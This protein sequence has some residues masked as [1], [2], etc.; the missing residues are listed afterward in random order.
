MHLAWDHMCHHYSKSGHEPEAGYEVQ[1]CHRAFGY[2]LWVVTEGQ[3]GCFLPQLSPS[4][5]PAMG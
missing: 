3:L 2:S 1:A 5:C 4:Q